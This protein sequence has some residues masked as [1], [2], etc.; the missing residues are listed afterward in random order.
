MIDIPS[1]NAEW[2]DREIP[3]ELTV[4]V[5]KLRAIFLLADALDKSHMGKIVSIKA[6][7]E[8]SMLF[9]YYKAELD[10]SLERWT[11]EKA[12]AVFE[13]VFGIS[14]KLMKG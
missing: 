8:D 4:I 1:D 9:I 12:A 13:E 5:S 3:R 10:I 11:F 6:K 7:L 14:P 2:I